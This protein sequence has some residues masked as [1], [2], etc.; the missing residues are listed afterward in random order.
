MV[1]PV[2]V[3]VASAH[4]ESRTT[5]TSGPSENSKLNCNGNVSDSTAAGIGQR[6][7][8]DICTT[9][10]MRPCVEIDSP[11]AGKC[12]WQRKSHRSSTV[13]LMQN[14]AFDGSG[15]GSSPVQVQCSRRR[16]SLYVARGYSAK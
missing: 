13:E 11:V 4:S 16:L 9:F 7:R 2:R 15:G 5:A 1:M 12:Q 10:S 6:P 14:H 8:L 3:A